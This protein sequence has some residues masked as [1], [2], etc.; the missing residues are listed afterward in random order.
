MIINYLQIIIF[1]LRAAVYIMRN[2][3]QYKCSMIDF[4]YEPEVQ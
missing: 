3:I 4:M 1:Y 2:L